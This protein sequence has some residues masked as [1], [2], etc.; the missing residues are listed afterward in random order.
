[1]KKAE[2]KKA[3]LKDRKADT[4]KLSQR[5]TGIVVMTSEI[6]EDERWTDAAANVREIVSIRCVTR[7]AYV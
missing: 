3:Q 2:A 1:M 4:K 7:L 5:R 6:T